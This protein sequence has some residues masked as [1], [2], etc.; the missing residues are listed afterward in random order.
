MS[1]NL[2]LA[3]LSDHLLIV[4]VVIYSLAMLAY[5]GD[6]AYGRR[7][8]A[9]SIT[10]RP[11]VPFPNWPASA[12]AGPPAPRNPSAVAEPGQPPA[13]DPPVTADPAA[14]GRE[15][16]GP[17]IRGAIAL[18]YLGLALHLAG[19]ITRGLAVHRVPWGDMYEFVTALTC[20]TVL[21][22]VALMMRYRAWHLGVFLTGAVVV[23]LGL[24]QTV[25]YTPAGPL[26]PALRSYWLA[27]HVAAMTL[28]VGI[29]FVA[30]VLGVVYLFA[31]RY[32]RRVAA[33]RSL[34][35]HGIMRRLPRRRNWTGSP[36][37]PWCSASRSGRSASSPARSGRTRRGAVTGG[38]TR[39]RRGPSSPGWSTHVSCTPGLRPAGAASGPPT[40]S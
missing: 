38:G 1:D 9:T 6:F 23:A 35:G 28:S 37:A 25:I 34:P 31:E 15:R 8:K 13:A 5:A 4:A 36:T 16:L 40:F 19:V 27:I 12:S 14:G 3:Q 2:G 26:V 33:G 22:F 32:S 29:F 21:F 30:A 39:S 10:R 11:P 18:T 7:A 20:V 24:A 17:L